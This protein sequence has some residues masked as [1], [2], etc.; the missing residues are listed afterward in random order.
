MS[1]ETPEKNQEE[2][3]K[4]MNERFRA[5]LREV[6]ESGKTS[7]GIGTYSESTLHAVLKNYYEPDTERHELRVG[8]YVADIVGEEG[9][10]EI[11][12]QQLFRIKEKIREFLPVAPVTVVCPVIKERVVVWRNA[13]TGEI[14]GTR[15][16][17]KHESIYSAMVELYSL[18]GYIR[19]PGFSFAVP[20]IAAEDIKDFK[21][22]KY[23]KKSETRRL[24]RIPTDLLYEETFSCPSDYSKI[25]PEG[26]PDIFT[27]EDFSK[28]AHISRSDARTVLSLLCETE[29]VSR[30]CREKKG[31]KYT[32]KQC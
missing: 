32:L 3:K 23:G 27:S 22:N 6:I 19:E 24:D 13:E 11:Q 30:I 7:N 17:P 29:T 1:I 26:L 25:V 28:C 10:V 2:N 8:R 31:W 16:S 5:A 4:M 15:K 14:T 20:V 12:T 18:R 21:L 9:I